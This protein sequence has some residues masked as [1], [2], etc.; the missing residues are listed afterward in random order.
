MPAPRLHLRFQSGHGHCMAV[1]GRTVVVLSHSTVWLWQLSDAGWIGVRT[2]MAHWY[3]MSGESGAIAFDSIPH[4]GS[5]L[6]LLFVANLSVRA[7]DLEASCM[8]NW[9]GRQHITLERGAVNVAARHPHVAVAYA[10]RKVRLFVRTDNVVATWVV[11]W[12][13]DLQWPITGL[14]FASSGKE[15]A[16]TMFRDGVVMLRQSDG[17]VTSRV[18]SS[19]WLQNLFEEADCWYVSTSRGIYKLDDLGS[20]IFRWSSFPEA[21]AWMTGVGLLTL[22]KDNAGIFVHSFPALLAMR[23]MSAART[24]WMIAAS[25][26]IQLRTFS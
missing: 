16:V 19:L 5:S 17:A 13:V 4:R 7:V 15:V 14:Q 26:A 25:R 11:L 6:P 18:P 20:S 10:N 12:V 24:A 21:M 1:W 9:V 8:V 2:I 22:R 23:A 3:M